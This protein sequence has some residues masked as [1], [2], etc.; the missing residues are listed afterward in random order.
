MPKKT[1][2]EGVKIWKESIKMSYI[3]LWRDKAT[4]LII[5]SGILL[6]LVV[7]I[8]MGWLLRRNSQ[9][10]IIGHYNVFFGID[11]I[12]DV[13]N[14]QSW[15]E[16]LFIPFGGLIFLGLS[17]MLS[18][19][20]MVQFNKPLDG[21]ANRNVNDFVTNKS[22]GFISSRLILIGAWTLQIVLLLYS[23]MILRIN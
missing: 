20:L 12:V 4:V 15:L 23:I 5:Y 3:L 6:N 11:A 16:I 7:W 17:F 22:I 1:N 18:V 21:D 9:G 2:N 14:R 13:T 8:I 19:L 10:V